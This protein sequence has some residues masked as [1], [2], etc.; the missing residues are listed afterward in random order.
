MNW[1]PPT[2]EQGAKL[3][4]HAEMLAERKEKP[5]RYPYVNI[6][7]QL[8]ILAACVFL[9][10]VEAACM[11]A[12]VYI[13]LVLPA[14]GVGIGHLLNISIH[15]QER[16]ETLERRVDDLELMLERIQSDAQKRW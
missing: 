1:Q 16:I 4:R 9:F 6:L 5:P 15:Y 7:I 14:G 10:G 2:G 13:L 3:A 12:I 11:T 8:S